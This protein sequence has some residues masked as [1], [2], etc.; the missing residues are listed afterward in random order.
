[1]I[2]TYVTCSPELTWRHWGSGWPRSCHLL[3]NL[4][5]STVTW[6]LSSTSLMF[7]RYPTHTLIA[8]ADLLNFLEQSPLSFLF[9]S[10]RRH[11]VSKPF[12]FF[13]FV[14]L[15]LLFR[16]LNFHSLAHVGIPKG[17]GVIQEKGGLC[18][19]QWGGRPSRHPTGPGQD[20]HH[21]GESLNQISSEKEASG[22]S[23]KGLL[24]F[25]RMH[26]VK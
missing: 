25:K 21:V 17:A 10:S 9:F 6:A 23:S 16:V 26:Q 15:I 1:M 22:W 18:Q 24:Y 3:M 5:R 7:T 8:F 11:L 14:L 2:V 13:F 19:C 20:E 4:S 12:P